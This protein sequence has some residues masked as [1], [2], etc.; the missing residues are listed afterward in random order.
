M[1]V[2]TKQKFNA[3]K[4]QKETLVNKMGKRAAPTH[5]PIALKTNLSSI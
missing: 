5:K 1:E 4:K 3:V 2:Q